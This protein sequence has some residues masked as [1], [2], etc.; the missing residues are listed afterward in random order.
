MSDKKNL[1]LIPNL[2]KGRLCYFT[3]KGIEFFKDLEWF[4][5]LMS[6]NKNN[7]NPNLYITSDEKIEKEDW[8]IAFGNTDTFILQCEEVKNGFLIS[9]ITKSLEKGSYPF[10][11][12]KC[13]KII[14]TTDVQLIEYGVQAIDD[15]FLVWFINNQSCESV[16][17]KQEETNPNYEYNWENRFTYKIIIPKEEPKQVGQ[18]TEKGVIDTIGNCA[19]CGTEFHIH[20]IEEQVE[21][22][23]YWIGIIKWNDGTILKTEPFY[24]YDSGIKQWSAKF[25]YE[26]RGKFESISY[27]RHDTINKEPEQYYPRV[28]RVEVIQHSKKDYTN[29]NAKDV[30]ISIQDKGRTLKVFLR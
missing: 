20:K 23:V 21:Q 14:L 29:Y 30:E 12:H 28:T 1:Y 25:S 17:I 6:V 22:K 18:V 19:N 5:K 13:K 3:K 4:K 24:E 8:Y 10:D 16:E 9:T 11:T 2:D 7:E 26:N 15:D 27:E